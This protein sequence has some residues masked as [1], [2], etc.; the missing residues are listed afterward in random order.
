M[1]L[2]DHLQKPPLW[3]VREKPALPGHMVNFFKRGEVEWVAVWRDKGPYRFPVNTNS[4]ISISVLKFTYSSRPLVR[5]D[6]KGYQ[7][8]IFS[9]KL[10][11]W[12]PKPLFRGYR[13]KQQT[14]EWKVLV[15]WL[16]CLIK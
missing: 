12:L 5:D 14:G 8:I 11:G 7:A 16:L 2:E 10:R 4:K 3:L 6:K 1:P 13:D 9:V 15:F